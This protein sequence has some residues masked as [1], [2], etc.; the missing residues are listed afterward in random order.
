[1]QQVLSLLGN[2]W[3]RDAVIILAAYTVGR[4]GIPTLYQDIKS[5]I[6]GIKGAVS[7]AKAAVTKSS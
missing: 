7:G 3:V 2:E 5:V 1:M 4:I 6:S